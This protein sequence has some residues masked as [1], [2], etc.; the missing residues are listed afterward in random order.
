MT[1]AVTHMTMNNFRSSRVGTMLC[2]GPS[3][4][5]NQQEID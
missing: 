5:M 1:P 2:A 3:L 4:G